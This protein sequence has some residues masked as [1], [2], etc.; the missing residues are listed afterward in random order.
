MDKEELTYYEQEFNML[1]D[2]HFQTSQKIISFFQFALLIFSAPIALLTSDQISRAVLGTVFIVIGIIEVLVIA[3]LSSLRAEALLYARQIN[4]IRNV[5]YSDGVLGK[6]KADINKK[7]ILFSQDKKP[8]YKDG[9]Q[10]IFIVL[11]LSLFSAF[12]VTFG[13]YKLLTSIFGFSSVRCVVIT[14]VIIG[15]LTLMVSYIVHKYIA[16]SAENG[17]AYY[18][19]IIGVD[20]DGVLNK[21]EE[22][23]VHVLGQLTGKKYGAEDI[24]SLPVHISTDISREEE[25]SVFETKEYWELQSLNND[26]NEYLN[27][28]IHNTLGFKTYIFTWRS[29]NVCKNIKGEK[30]SFDIED[31]TKQWLK[32]NGVVFN[33]IK[34]EKG[35]YDSP[36]SLFNSRYKTRYYYAQK[37]KIRYFVEDNARNAEKLS[38]ICEYVFLIDHPYNQNAKLPYNVIRVSGWKDIS[39]WI[40]QLN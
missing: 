6:E 14:S 38:R 2:A 31:H 29:W 24:R 17:V 35:N 7:K 8:D 18:K 40:K 11:V 36:I 27:E 3:Y 19:Q 25:H 9:N 33:K 13:S 1:K 20:I 39:E 10:F 4:R 30:L 23:F 15:C 26:V 12:Y 21:H 16:I 22:T 34:F 32:K 28:E 37:Y 5:I